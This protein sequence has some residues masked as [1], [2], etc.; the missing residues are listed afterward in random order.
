MQ[1]LWS[2]A[3]RDLLWDRFRSE[4]LRVVYH[5]QSADAIPLNSLDETI[6]VTL[7][8]QPKSSASELTAMLAEQLSLSAAE[9]QGYVT[10][11]LDQLLD[12][13]LVVRE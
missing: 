12:V 2:L 8:S 9:L 5:P 7:A 6:L 10:A 3:N 13:G 1:G 4:E 11:A